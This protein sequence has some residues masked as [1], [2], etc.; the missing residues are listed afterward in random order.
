MLNF[1][2]IRG[3]CGKFHFGHQGLKPP[4]TSEFVPKKDFRG[5][6]KVALLGVRKAPQR[7]RKDASE[8]FGTNLDPF[9]V[10]R[11]LRPK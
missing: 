11:P 1:V 2:F 4:L 5:E 8:F 3:T 6:Q 9:G 10:S 7:D